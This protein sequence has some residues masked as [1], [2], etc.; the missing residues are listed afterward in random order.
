MHRIIELLQQDPYRLA[1]LTVVSHL[2]L[3]HCYVAAGFV[4]NLV[5]DHLHQAARTQLNDIDIIYFDAN[6][7]K[8]DGAESAMNYL[9]HAEHNAQLKELGTVNWQIKNQAVMHGKNNDP[10]YHSIADA[11]SFWP[12]KE[13]A[14]A[15]RLN[16]A[17]EIEVIAPFGLDSLFAGEI[18]P[19]P[20]RHFSI[21]EQRL[22][23]KAWLKTWPNLKV[24]S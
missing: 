24:V 18:T 1:I 17:D 7:K 14:V 3:P 10:R 4:R 12:E 2:N 16:Q 20:K 22:I 23:Q 9:K 5:W 13:T 21:F 11:M 8:S 15:V 6:D 19:N